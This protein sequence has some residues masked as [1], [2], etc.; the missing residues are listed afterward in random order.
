VSDEIKDVSTDLVPV[1]TDL[2]MLT[3]SQ[4]VQSNRIAE[5][6]RAIVE[7]TGVMIGPKK[8]I[9]IEAWQ[10]VAA[11]WGC[12]PGTEE[13]FRVEGDNPGWR[14]KA[15][16]KR[17]SDG[18]I[19]ST[20]FGFVGDDESK[21]SEGPQHSREG[22][23]QTR[24]MSRVIANKFR[25][26]AV[27]MQIENLSTTPAEEMPGYAGGSGNDA[28]PAGRKSIASKPGKSVQSKPKAKQTEVT[29]VITK[30]NIAKGDA[31]KGDCWFANSGSPNTG[32]RK[33][34]W[35]REKAVGE[36]IHK[37]SGEL[38]TLTVS[39]P[40]PNKPDA[41]QVHNARPAEVEEE[42]END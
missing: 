30:G 5:L 31:G 39:Q 24:A 16:L 15:Y 8:H 40:N 17:D 42:E 29:L 38:M 9:V 36:W 7:R 34:Y 3:D 20:A 27:L 1:T 33:G 6:C 26:I 11:A 12:T 18:A 2:A 25:F 13:P 35:T 19:L 21:W 22:M 41:Y 37:H 10:S 23:V 4:W 28:A 14:C 32:D